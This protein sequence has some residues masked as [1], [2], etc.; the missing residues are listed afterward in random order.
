MRNKLSVVLA[1]G[2]LLAALSGTAAA[3]GNVGF[4]VSVGGPGYA[5]AYGP[6]PVYAAP[7]VYYAPAQPA[8]YG[9]YVAPAPVYYGPRA[10]YAPPV[11][12]YPR[13][14]RH[15]GWYQDRGYRGRG[16]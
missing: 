5:F 16:W 13:Y 4:S 2:A 1:G 14:Y 6:A 7:P 3:H 12:A 9:E 11:V 15:H 8:Y 10:Y